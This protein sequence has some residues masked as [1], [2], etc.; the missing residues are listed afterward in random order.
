M[1]LSY[2]ERQDV[3]KTGS[4][5]FVGEMVLSLVDNSP[6]G[7]ESE[8]VVCDESGEPGQRHHPQS[9]RHQWVGKVSAKRSAAEQNLKA[10][11]K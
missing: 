2:Q 4:V 1:F 5:N 10:Q 11:Q 7:D 8:C 3:P 9:P 6:G